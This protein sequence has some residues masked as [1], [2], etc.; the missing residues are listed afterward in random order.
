[1]SNVREIA[2]FTPKKLAEIE[3]FAFNFKTMGA[4]ILS[5]TI[6]E[7]AVNVSVEAG[8]DATPNAMKIGSPIADPANQFRVLQKIGGGVSG[9]CYRITVTIT[10]NIGNVYELEGLLTVI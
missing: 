5:Q 9:V 2:P 1:M 6:T 8:T 10:T 3:D 7:M 4:F